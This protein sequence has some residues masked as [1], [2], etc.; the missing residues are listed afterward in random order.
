MD[1]MYIDDEDILLQVI[2]SYFE[3]LGCAADCFNTA[4]DGLDNIGAKD[5]KVIMVDYN[6]PNTDANE[7]IMQIRAAKNVKLIVTSGET[8][9]SID[10]DFDENKLYFIKKPF[11]INDL[12]DLMKKIFPDENFNI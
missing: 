11:T 4:Q 12:A 2:K 9:E 6:M 8:K 3:V 1:V 10:L 7:L 5:Y